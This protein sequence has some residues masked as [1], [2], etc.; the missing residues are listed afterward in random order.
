MEKEKL[1]SPKKALKFAD[2]GVEIALAIALIAFIVVGLI[3][4][5]F[6][7]KSGFGNPNGDNLDAELAL[8]NRPRE[9][10]EVT[11]EKK[12]V[13]G[14]STIT[15]AENWRVVSLSRDYTSDNNYSC[16]GIDQ[17]SCMVYS[18]SNNEV[19]YYISTPVQLQTKVDI[20]VTTEKKD[21]Q[22]AGK[23][24]SFSFDRISIYAENDKGELVENDSVVIYKEVYGCVS[25]TLCVSSGLLNLEDASV[26][27]SQVEKFQNFV[28][29]LSLN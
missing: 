3:I 5:L 26:N 4:F 9:I 28:E 11:D 18:I 22:V 19:I 24:V 1:K 17:E 21:I 14:E 10:L 29:G 20:P 16:N 7:N 12:V 8:S 15:L 6:A 13:V 2:R 23:P 27:K 25:S